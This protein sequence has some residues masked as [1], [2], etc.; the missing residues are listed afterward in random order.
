MK[1]RDVPTTCI[2]VLAALLISC[3]T[4]SGVAADESVPAGLAGNAA[5]LA[6]VDRITL[7]AVNA[8]ELRAE[9]SERA[10]TDQ[11]PRF[12]VAFAYTTTPWNA[13]TWETLES[14]EKLWRLR[15][16]SQG[17]SSLNFGFGRYLMPAGAELFVYNPDG[18]SVRGPFTDKDNEV[19]G[20]LWTPVVLGGEAVI[21]LI[22]PEKMLPYLK[23]ELTSINHGYKDFWVAGGEKSGSCNVDVICPE[24][25]DW[26]DEIRS[27]GVISTGGSTFCSGFMVNNTDNDNTPYFMTAN[28]CGIT[29]ANAASLVV[30]WNYETSTCGG[31]LDGTLD[32]YQTGSIFRATRY[33]SDFTL[34]ELDD[35]PDEAF[36]VHWA[37]WDNSDADPTSATAIHHPSTDEKRISFENDPLTTTSYLAAAVPGDSTHLRVEDWDVGTTEGGSSGSGLWNQDHRIVGQLHGGYASC[38]SDTA[39]W[40]GRFSVS[41]DTGTTAATRLKDWLDPGNTGAVTVDGIDQ[42]PRPSVDFTVTPNPAQVGV[43]V[44][45]DATVSGGIPPYSYAWDVDGDGSTDYTTEDISHSYAE[46][47]SG[48]VRLVVTDGYPCPA[49]SIHHIA[50]GC[51]DEDGDGYGGM[52]SPLCTYPEEDCDDTDPDVNPGVTEDCSNGIDDDCDGLAD[53]ADSECGAPPWGSASTVQASAAGVQTKSNA[54]IHNTL[55]VLLVPMGM[56]LLLRL[57]RKNR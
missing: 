20:Q 35:A 18:S 57:R 53:N 7:P 54:G 26:R 38:T 23:L 51:S 27:V 9:D 33:A 19:H 3:L 34:V 25:D 45:F 56:L 13:G 24:G 17:A 30:Y 41:W 6:S 15:V 11:P 48:S 10:L 16:L 28:H 49:T 1:R 31:P 5:S 32:Q 22:I 55:A 47:F 21:E 40:Y 2:A 46:P 29:A 14:G 36:N 37:G 8:D 39:D 52:A 44:D 50:V 4:F 43:T 12:A 42:C